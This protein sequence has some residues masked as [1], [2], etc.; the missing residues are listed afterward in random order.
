MA[1]FSLSGYIVLMELGYL[2]NLTE[3]APTS[4]RSGS[5]L[6]PTPDANDPVNAE[7]LRQA[8]IRDE[9]EA[10]QDLVQDGGQPTHRPNES[11]S[12]YLSEPQNRTDIISYW[13]TIC[14][15]V[16]SILEQQRWH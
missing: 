6:S 9:H 4:P 14:F 3:V 15:G 16:E 5:S 11:G 10:Y 1:E 2:R 7:L 8:R 13:T 12:E